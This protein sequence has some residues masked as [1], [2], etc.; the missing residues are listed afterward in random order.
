[1]KMA[2][3]H[4]LKSLNAEE[5]TQLFRFLQMYYYNIE[6]VSHLRAAIMDQNVERKFMVQCLTNIV[7]NELLIPTR[8]TSLTT[9]I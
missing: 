5:W 1:M 2:L 6:V 9:Y 7:L 4:I 3:K 8:Y